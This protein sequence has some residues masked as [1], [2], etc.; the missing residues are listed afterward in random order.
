MRW[1]RLGDF[2]MVQGNAWP[3]ALEGTNLRYYSAIIIPLT[4]AAAVGCVRHVRSDSQLLVH[5]RRP[6]HPLPCRF[7]FQTYHGSAS[8]S[9]CSPHWLS[10]VSDGILD[11]RIR[12]GG[13]GW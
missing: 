10:I 8:L 7:R 9:R 13:R 12:A 4:R 3:A 2:I 6:M 5:P 11:V 1:H